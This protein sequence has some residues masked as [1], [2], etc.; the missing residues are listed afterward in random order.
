MLQLASSIENLCALEL[1]L[2]TAINPLDQAG[3]N[4]H[5]VSELHN[6]RQRLA[7]LTCT[8]V[9]ENVVPGR[10]LISTE[11]AVCN[12]ISQHRKSLRESQTITEIKL[13]AKN[14]GLVLSKIDLSLL[15]LVEQLTRDLKS[16]NQDLP[17]NSVRLSFESEFFVQSNDGKIIMPEQFLTDSLYTLFTSN[18]LEISRAEPFHS[19]STDHLLE[20][21]NLNSSRI[22]SCASQNLTSY[23]NFR[24]IVANFINERIPDFNFIRH[25]EHLH[26]SLADHNGTT[27]TLEEV[28]PE[29]VHLLEMSLRLHWNDAILLLEHFPREKTNYP[30]S[31]LATR[32]LV[33]RDEECDFDHF[34]VARELEPLRNDG[35]Q[36]GKLHYEV[37]R[38]LPGIDSTDRNLP[39][40]PMVFAQA[41]IVAATNTAAVAYLNPNMKVF[42]LEQTECLEEAADDEIE[43]MY[44]RWSHTSILRLPCSFGVSLTDRIK[45]ALGLIYG[46]SRI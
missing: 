43:N 8:M 6:L 26:F 21:R 27:L 25:S 20:T 45:N 41:L 7:D 14:A 3:S 4:S 23:F 33:G 5:K 10:P 15:S 46:F 1:E 17:A 16:T 13:L 34:F 11:I 22:F 19:S 12:L 30:S 31:L 39:C 9:K 24:S 28:D 35:M 2:E 18:D 36:R 37:R 38:L 40:H 44:E 29:F 32:N 42:L